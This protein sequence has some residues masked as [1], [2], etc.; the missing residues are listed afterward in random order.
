MPFELISTNKEHRTCAERPGVDLAGSGNAATP[1]MP[2]L[3]F[4]DGP[5]SALFIPASSG[6]HRCQKN[7]PF[8]AKQ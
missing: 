7:Q 2:E 5:L 1:R 4:A 6:E 8:G 3:L